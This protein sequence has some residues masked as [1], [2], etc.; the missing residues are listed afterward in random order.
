MANRADT[1]NRSDSST[2][3]GTPS[4]GGSAWVVVAGTWGVISNTG[5]CPTDSG[6]QNIAYLECSEADGTVAVDVT[7]LGFAGITFRYSDSSNYW[8]LVESGGDLL[9]YKNVAGSF[10]QVGGTA[11]GV[12]TARYSV[13][14]SGSSIT[15]RANG[16]SA[17]ITGT[18]SH[19]STATKHGLRTYSS[20]AAR[21]DNFDFTGTG[22]GG[23]STG[24]GLTSSPLL[25]GRLLRGL[26]R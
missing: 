19:N 25:S 6:S 11:F 16:G 13:D 5:Y 21:F 8:L 3:L 24:A 17:L 26:V 4:D 23:S 12:G 20:T 9:L 22:G 2:A 1:F 15:V 7:T 18:D 14:L 10:T